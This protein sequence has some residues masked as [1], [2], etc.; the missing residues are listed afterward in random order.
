MSS[1]PCVSER[2]CM[3]KGKRCSKTTTDSKRTNATTLNSNLKTNP[4]VLLLELELVLWQLV[5]VVSH[6]DEKTT[7]KQGMQRE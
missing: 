4:F 2:T 6:T 1:H 7:L 5:V 3:G